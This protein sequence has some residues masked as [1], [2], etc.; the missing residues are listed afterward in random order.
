MG[1]WNCPI[2]SGADLAGFHINAHFLSFRGRGAWNFVERQG[3]MKKTGI[4]RR[5][6]D[7][8]R[9]AIPKE[10]RRKAGITVGTPMEIFTTPDG[11][12]LKEYNVTGDLLHIA[13]ALSSAVDDSVGYLEEEKASAIRQHITGIINLLK[14]QRGIEEGVWRG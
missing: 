14:T 10:V 7:L 5:V 2:L 12:V 4:I 9:V 3:N 11:I 1:R 13:S 6:D 8:G